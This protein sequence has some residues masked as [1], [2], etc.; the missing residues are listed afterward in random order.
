M[1]FGRKSRNKGPKELA[2][3]TRSRL[4]ASGIQRAMSFWFLSPSPIHLASTSNCVSLD[5]VSKEAPTSQAFQKKQGRR[6]RTP[7]WLANNPP[8]KNPSNLGIPL[9]ESVGCFNADFCQ[10][11]DRLATCLAREL[12]AHGED[13]RTSPSFCCFVQ[14]AAKGSIERYQSRHWFQDF[15]CVLLCWTCAGISMRSREK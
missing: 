12:L 11:L 10:A 5:P 15:Q 9:R 7:Q 1:F 2:K 4:Q 3:M 13:V 6:T 8:K 14:L